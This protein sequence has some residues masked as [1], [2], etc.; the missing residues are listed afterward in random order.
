MGP[1][2]GSSPSNRTVAV[3]GCGASAD[4][5]TAALAP[6]GR[7]PAVF[8]NGLRC[9]V[10]ARY[11][12]AAA[13]HPARRAPLAGLSAANSEAALRARRGLAYFRGIGS[14]EQISGANE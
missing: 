13:R 1:S 8:G 9:L 10:G 3:P 2:R 7:T 11:A 5:I 14:I 6:A 4:A 12:V